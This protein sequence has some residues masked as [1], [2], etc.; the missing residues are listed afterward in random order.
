MAILIN[1]TPHAISIK[2]ADFA[3]T[4]QPSGIL[5]RVSTTEAVSGSVSGCIPVVTRK[6]GDVEF[7]GDVS[8]LS[9]GEKAVF[10]V[11]AM[12]LDALPATSFYAEMFFAPDTGSTAERNDM[13]HIVSVCRLVGK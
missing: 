2:T 13:G 10:L 5:A 7:T 11:S 6:L 1:L 4:V 9:H 3:V 12:V 8:A